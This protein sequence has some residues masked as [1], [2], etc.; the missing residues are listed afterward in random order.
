MDVS[1]LEQWEKDRAEGNELILKNAGLQ[2]KRLMHIDEEAYKEGALTVKTK[3]LL[4]LTASMV[5]RCD[6]CITYHIRRCHE[7]GVT[8]QELEEAILVSYV[9]GGSIVVPH[10]RRAFARWEELQKGEK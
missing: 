7:I 1:T 8:S 10:M 5:L 3:E 6:D 2:M 9:V 4:G